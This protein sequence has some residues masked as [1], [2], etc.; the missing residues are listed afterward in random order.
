LVK[1]PH[2]ALTGLCYRFFA[3][4][5][6][7]IKATETCGRSSKQASIESAFLDGSRTGRSK[8]FSELNQGAGT[9][10]PR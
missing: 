3:H 2:N 8:A 4:L 7:K 10:S 9:S 5:V 1:H 6:S